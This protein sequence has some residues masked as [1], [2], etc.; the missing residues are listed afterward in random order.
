M[1]NPSGMFLHARE[2]GRRRGSI[3]EVTDYVHFSQ[4]GKQ[5]Q[6]GLLGLS[7]ASGLVGPGF[8]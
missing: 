5:C 1:I 6:V 7:F 2:S 3:Y 8:S 4:S